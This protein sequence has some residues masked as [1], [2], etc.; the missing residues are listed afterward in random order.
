MRSSRSS[1]TLPGSIGVLAVLGDLFSAWI[2]RE[3]LSARTTGRS[4][5]AFRRLRRRGCRLGL[6]RGE[7]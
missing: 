2:G 7:P 4:L 1:N 6:R 3:D 5:D